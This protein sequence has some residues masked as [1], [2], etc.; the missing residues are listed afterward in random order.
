MPV[1]VNHQYIEWHVVRAK[2]LNQLFKFLIGVRPVTR[3]PGSERESR[4]QRD[5]SRH[6]REIGERAL[7]I[8]SIAKEA[9][10]LPTARR[11]QD[12]PRPATLF[13]ASERESVGIEQRTGPIVHCRPA[14]TR[15]N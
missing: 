8:V 11:S 2:S 7:V 14:V 5:L 15:D 13:P 9:P 1:Y 10:P 12:P 4:R 6:L 3:P